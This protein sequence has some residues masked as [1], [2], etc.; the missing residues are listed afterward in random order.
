MATP[1]GQLTEINV[2]EFSRVLGHDPRRTKRFVQNVVQSNLTFGSLVANNLCDN[3][4]GSDLCLK[5]INNSPS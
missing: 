1:V 2:S 3:T 4:G 5:T